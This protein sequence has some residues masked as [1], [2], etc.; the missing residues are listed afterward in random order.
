MHPHPTALQTSE[1]HGNDGPIR[2]FQINPWSVDT[3]AWQPLHKPT[4]QSGLKPRTA[5]GKPA[6]ADYQNNLV[7]ARLR[8]LQAAVR[9]FMPGGSIPGG[10]IGRSVLSEMVADLEIHILP[11]ECLRLRAAHHK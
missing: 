7:E 8:V 2:V 6:K 9:V 11:A 4:H 10:T 5:D 3:G 1:A